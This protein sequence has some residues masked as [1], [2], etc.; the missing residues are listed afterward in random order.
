MSWIIDRAP[1]YKLQMLAIRG[2]DDYQNA[3][4]RTLD[5]LTVFQ[6]PTDRLDLLVLFVTGESVT[7]NFHFNS[8]TLNLNTLQKMSNRFNIVV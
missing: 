4:N 7:A 2:I 3:S 8:L 1:N 5:I 6:S